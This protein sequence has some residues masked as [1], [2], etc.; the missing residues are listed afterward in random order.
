ME[1]YWGCGRNL[2]STICIEDD[3]GRGTPNQEGAD[4]HPFGRAA[5]RAA[6]GRGEAL[7]PITKRRGRVSDSSIARVGA[8]GRVMRVTAAVKNRGAIVV[9]HPALESKC[10]A[11]L[12]RRRATAQDRLHN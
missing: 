4:Q 12:T 1:K 7:D 9:A 3:N 11:I 8:E 5:A 6:R 10:T 2:P